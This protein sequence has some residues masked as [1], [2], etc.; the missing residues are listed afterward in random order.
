[1]DPR[2]YRDFIAERNEP[3]SYMTFPHYSPS[4]AEGGL[5]RVG[6][7]ARCNISSH[8]GSPKSDRELAE[9]RQRAGAR[10]PV[11]HSFAYHLARCIEILFALERIEELLTDPETLRTDTLRARAFS[12]RS[13]GIGVTEAPRGT[14][15]HNYTAGS[16]GVIRHVDFLIATAQNNA[17]MNRTIQQI[18]MHLIR[19][20]AK[21]VDAGILQRI[22]AGIRCYDPC[23]SCATH[24]LGKMPLL[25]EYRNEDDSLI[26]SFRR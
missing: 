18:A 4:G 13:Q 11:L 5:Y 19:D 20:A 14:L 7:L 10:S 17:A 6:P 1:V 15:F 25:I 23:F 3:W 24:A 22:E 26:R 12:N 8:T 21:D 9:F 2:S 16:D